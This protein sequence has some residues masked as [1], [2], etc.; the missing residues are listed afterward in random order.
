M[1]L[2]RKIFLLLYPLSGGWEEHQ[3]LEVNGFFIMEKN[4]CG[5]MYGSHWGV[6][7]AGVWLGSDRDKV[8]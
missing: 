2:W 6:G 5:E 4:L 3:G 8:P 1:E 7:S